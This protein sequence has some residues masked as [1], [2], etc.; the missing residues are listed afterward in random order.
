MKYRYRNT[1]TGEIITTSN[2]VGGKKWEPVAD[3]CAQTFED[4]IC[5]AEVAEET[6]AEEAPAEK[7]KTTRRGEK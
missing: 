2:R 4:A 5:D 3:I 1:K 7:P 6:V